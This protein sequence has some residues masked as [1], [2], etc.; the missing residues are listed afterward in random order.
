MTPGKIILRAHFSQPCGCVMLVTKIHQSDKREEAPTLLKME[1]L[2]TVVWE[3]DYILF[4]IA[5]FCMSKS[6]LKQRF[7]VIILSLYTVILV[8]LPTCSNFLNF[9]SLS[10]HSASLFH[11][12]LICSVQPIHSQ[13]WSWPLSFP[14]LTLHLGLWSSFATELD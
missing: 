3:K 12:S 10:S 2:I 5:T 1:C 8:S 9:H 11:W 4:Y 14:L 7:S 6:D 13:F